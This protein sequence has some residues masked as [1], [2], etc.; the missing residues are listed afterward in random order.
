MNALETELGILLFDRSG[1]R[2]V[3]NAHGLQMLEAAQR[4][5]QITTRR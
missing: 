1:R 3:L 2:S 4:L 5:V